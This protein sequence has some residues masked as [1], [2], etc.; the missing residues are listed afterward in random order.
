MELYSAPFVVRKQ[1]GRGRPR[2][3]ANIGVTLT[4][5]N[6][7]PYIT[8]PDVHT[9]IEATLQQYSH[10]RVPIDS[11]AY[12][13]Q[14]QSVQI[15]R[16]LLSSN[17]AFRDRRLFSEASHAAEHL[18]SLQAGAIRSH[19]AQ[20]LITDLVQQREQA[21]D[22]DTYLKTALRPH[23]G[24]NIDEDLFRRTPLPFSSISEVSIQLCKALFAKE[25]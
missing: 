16:S 23:L 2:K 1:A 14:Q 20:K 22:D 18:A 19:L 10:F 17:E 8:K 13:A 6:K 21:K 12:Q 7:L 3:Q 4:D 11:P 5:A 24:D 25:S 9:P 15:H